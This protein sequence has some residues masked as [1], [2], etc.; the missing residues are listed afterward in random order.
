MENKKPPVIVTYRSAVALRDAGIRYGILRAGQYA[1]FV[2]WAGFFLV[3]VG[4]LLGLLPR[5][6]VAIGILGIVLTVAGA[7]LC[8]TKIEFP[9]A[10][11]IFT[12]ELE[13]LAK[14]GVPKHLLQGSVQNC[15]CESEDGHF[16]KQKTAEQSSDV[17]AA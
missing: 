5:V 6:T 14:A 9:H 13:A 3:A 17:T 16:T 7:Y 2:F 10:P 15:L 1:S 11:R 12:A 8:A 4:G